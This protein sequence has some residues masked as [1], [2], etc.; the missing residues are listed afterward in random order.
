MHA[1]LT[2]FVCCESGDRSANL[3]QV[4]LVI[5]PIRNA[6]LRLDPSASLLTS[7]HVLLVKL[8]LE[9]R[10]YEAVL[11]VIDKSIFQFPSAA[12]QPKPE[13]L[14]DMR[15]PPVAF[16]TTETKLTTKVKYQDVLEYFLYSGMVYMGLRRWENSLECLENAVTYPSKE[17]SRIMVEAYKKWVLVG[18]L[19][20]GKLLQ[21]PKYTSI[22]AA[23]AYHT[24]AKPYETVAQ[25]FETGSAPRL[26]AEVEIGHQ[27][28]EDDS[29]MGLILNVLSEY[30]KF[31]IRNLASIY[32]KIS[33]PEVN[34]LTTSA[35]TGNKL[36][37][38]I[39]AEGLVRGMI[40]DGSLD[41]TLSN[42]PG[43]SA[44]LTFKPSGSKL[45]EKQ[46][47]EELQASKERI[48]LLA[49]E[50]K[51][52]DRMLTYD[53]EYLKF[54]Q[55]QQRLARDGAADQG[56]AGGDLDWNS[57]EDEDIMTGL[58]F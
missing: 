18:L 17:V 3:L 54:V 40:A 16:V 2:R 47:E 48:Q 41:A 58:T 21:L 43:G 32:S 57:V 53:K 14:S 30:Q 39:L 25:I 49:Q 26:K 4:A 22:N 51:R 52:T 44:I 5:K 38:H 12:N 11:P 35:E 6:I 28:W 37:S 56:I 7:T 50:V 8:A 31:Q 19:L 42:P 34:Q 24:I 46:V 20:E 13:S 55:K 9:A 10:D 1:L 45:S 23:K 29:N 36:Q 27:I 33:I 15:L